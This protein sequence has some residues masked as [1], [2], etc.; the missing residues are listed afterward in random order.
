MTGPASSSP[1]LACRATLRAVQPEDEPFLRQVYATTRAD[2]MALVNWDESQKQAFLN[3]QFEAQHRYYQQQF[4]NAQ[5]QIVELDGRPIGRLY[6]DRREDEIRII[7]IALLP[8]NRN[9]GIGSALLRN[10]LNEAAEAGKPVR[11]HVEQFNP[12]LRLYKRLRFSEVGSYG[13]YLLMEWRP[14]EPHASPASG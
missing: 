2:E 7:D 3:M 10:I 13:L 11:I 14:G 12:A 6:V 4:Q 8:E 5:F 9:S 1:T